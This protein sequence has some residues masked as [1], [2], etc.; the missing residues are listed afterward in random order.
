MIAETLIPRN[1]VKDALAVHI[2]PGFLE[3]ENSACSEVDA[4]I[5]EI[6]ANGDLLECQAQRFIGTGLW[7]GSQRHC[8]SLSRS[9]G[10]H[11]LTCPL[12]PWSATSA[13]AK[14]Y[15]REPT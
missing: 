9:P 10:R 14:V 11:I 15:P 5:V 2:D 4:T 6:V 12:H 7:G 13:G 3:A 1:V 8:S